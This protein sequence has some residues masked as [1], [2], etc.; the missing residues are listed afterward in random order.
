MTHPLQRMREKLKSDGV[1]P[2][3]PVQPQA[4]AAF[5]EH[6][7]VRLPAD[8]RAYFSVCDG[9]DD[10]VMD[11]DMF[12]FWDLSRLRPIQEELPN[13]PAYREFPG[14]NRFLCFADW[15]ISADIFAIELHS[16]P[17]SAN[18]VFALGPRPLGISSFS[19]FV[20]AYLRECR[21]LLG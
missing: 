15:S 14:A 1:A 7:K 4:L 5:E 17:T 20:D 19:D 21:A 6:Y 9:M 13:E 18:R 11:E 2:R 3:P 8:F 16:D 12:S 10:G